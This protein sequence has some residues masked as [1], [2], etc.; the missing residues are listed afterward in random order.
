MTVEMISCIYSG[1]HL[2]RKRMGRKPALVEMVSWSQLRYSLSLL[3]QATI[4]R[5]EIRFPSR[6]L[7]LVETK[8]WS[9]H[10]RSP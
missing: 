5:V 9:L 2:G 7:A 8:M 10:S 3:K 4:G 1:A 6:K